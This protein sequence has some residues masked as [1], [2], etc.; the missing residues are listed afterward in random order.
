MVNEKLISLY[1]PRI[2][3]KPVLRVSGKIRYKHGCTTT[4][5]ELRLETLDFGRSRVALST[6]PKT[7]ALI[8]RC[9]FAL[10]YA[11]RMFSHDVAH[12]IS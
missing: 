8:S 11:E 12:M 2:V 3:R 7:K 4:E 10:A 5:D 1:E 9:A 6:W